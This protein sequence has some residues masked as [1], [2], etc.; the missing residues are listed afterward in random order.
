MNRV[1]AVVGLTAIFA[2]R[3]PGAEAAVA[4]AKIPTNAVLTLQFD[5]TEFLIG[6]NILSHYVISNRGGAAFQIDVGGDYRGGTRANR[7]KVT[8]TRN[9]GLVVEDPNPVQ[10]EMGGLSPSAAVA[11]GTNWYENVWLARYCRFLDPGEYEVKVFHDFGWGPRQTND[12]RELTSVI[13]LRLPT[14]EQ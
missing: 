3:L 1:L 2:G 4:P 11:P 7:F 6:E 14:E 13:K 12:A 5:K 8:A 9:D 10:W